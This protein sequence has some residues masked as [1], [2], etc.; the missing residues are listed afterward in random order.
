MAVTA[1]V[2]ESPVETRGWVGGGDKVA[3]QLQSPCQVQQLTGQ[4]GC[5]EGHS[6]SH[7]ANL[8][9]GWPPG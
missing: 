2:L 4:R 3:L 9:R 7:P 5:P 8:G 1:P 6:A